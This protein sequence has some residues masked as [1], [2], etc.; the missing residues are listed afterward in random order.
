MFINK[1]ILTC[2]RG[3][4]MNSMLNAIVIIIFEFVF[5]ML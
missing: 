3:G 2:D 4:L 1:Y 5:Y